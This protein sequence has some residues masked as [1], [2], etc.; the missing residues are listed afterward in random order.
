MLGLMDRRPNRVT[1]LGEGV[2]WVKCRRESRKDLFGGGGEGAG[3]C[4]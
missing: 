4:G 1:R 2:F 3:G